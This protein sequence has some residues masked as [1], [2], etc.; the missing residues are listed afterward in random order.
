MVRR[1]NRK[2]LLAI[3][4]PG[5]VI[6]TPKLDRMF[7]SALNALGVLEGLKQQGVSL[8][9]ID[10]GRADRQIGK[11]HRPAERLLDPRPNAVKRY[12]EANG[13]NGNG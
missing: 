7:R 3:L 8:H 4:K 6:I 11:G 12:D 5:D 1:S 10:L 9:M 2:A 13:E